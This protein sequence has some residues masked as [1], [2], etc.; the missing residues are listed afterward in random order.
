[1]IKWSHVLPVLSKI[2]FA[3]NVKQ[4]VLN[5]R[6]TGFQRTIEDYRVYQ[7]LSQIFQ[8][9]KNWELG[10]N[11]FQRN[12]QKKQIF[13][14]PENVRENTIWHIYDVYKFKIDILQQWPSFDILKVEKMATLCFSLDFCIF[15]I[16]KVV[17]R[18][19]PFRNALASFSCSLQKVDQKHASRH[20]K[21]KFSVAPSLTSWP[22]VTLTL[23]FARSGGSWC[24]HPDVSFSGSTSDWL[25]GLRWNF[26]QLMLPPLRNFC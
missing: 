11:I 3:G 23:A 5:I 4:T 17:F 2:T 9:L 13:W 15:P 26:A 10:N 22:W 18:F 16:A 8:T 24:H 14:K 25:G 20:P 1:M 21:P 12:S 7:S 19:W 6:P